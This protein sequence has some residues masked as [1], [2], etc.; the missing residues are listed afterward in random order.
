VLPGDLVRIWDLCD[1]TLVVVRELGFRKLVRLFGCLHSSSSMRVWGTA[2]SENSYTNRLR[3]VASWRLPL[4]ALRA[5]A[6]Y[7][8]S[9]GITT[10]LRP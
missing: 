3:N 8:S 4:L 1:L 5:P 10:N 9:Y 7:E 6:I 2:V